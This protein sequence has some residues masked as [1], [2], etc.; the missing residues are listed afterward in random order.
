M[1]VT[2]LGNVNASNS[3]NN[4]VIGHFPLLPNA[5]ANDRVCLVDLHSFRRHYH[6]PNPNL[7]PTHRDLLLLHRLR[8]LNEIVREKGKGSVIIKPNSSSSKV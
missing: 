7:L 8:L 2:P 4:M 3:N 1:I 6:I 5:S